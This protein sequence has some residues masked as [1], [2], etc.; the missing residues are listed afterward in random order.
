MNRVA[1]TVNINFFI[2]LEKTYINPEVF[3]PEKW[4]NLAKNSEFYNILTSSLPI[5]LELNSAVA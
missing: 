1:K 3:I 2:T 4:W 5:S